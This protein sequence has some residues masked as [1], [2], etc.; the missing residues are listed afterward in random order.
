MLN[1]KK[2]FYS[3]TEHHQ[4]FVQVSQLLSETQGMSAHPIAD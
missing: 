4:E 2:L 3:Q 1:R